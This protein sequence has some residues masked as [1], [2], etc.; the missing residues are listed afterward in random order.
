LAA[1]QGVSLASAVFQ[2][3]AAMAASAAVTWLE[4]GVSG[5]GAACGCSTPAGT[6][7]EVEEESREEESREEESRE[8]ESRE[9][10][11]RE[12]EFWAE[13]GRKPASEARSRTKKAVR[14][15]KSLN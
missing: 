8:E 6:G 14:S 10:E 3:E 11:S 1:T 13:A 15:T 9:E 2:S 5:A 12:E 7:P 4:A